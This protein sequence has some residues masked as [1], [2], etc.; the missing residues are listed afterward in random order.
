M[1][2]R[3]IPQEYYDKMFEHFMKHKF[4]FDKEHLDEIGAGC[5][6]TDI[7]QNYYPH[8]LGTGIVTPF[9]KIPEL[10]EF[11]EQLIELQNSPLA[12]ALE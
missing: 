4:A 9:L 2:K 5:S 6:F 3:K 10:R 12:K 1:I 11:G 7:I 8:L